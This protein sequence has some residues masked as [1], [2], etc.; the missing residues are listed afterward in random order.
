MS[1]VPLRL[2]RYPFSV[3][4]EGQLEAES[5]VSNDMSA[6]SIKVILYF[7]SDGTR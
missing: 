1:K 3:F 5:T 6:N 4:L 7:V 2:P